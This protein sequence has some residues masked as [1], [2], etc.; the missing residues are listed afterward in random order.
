MHFPC[1]GL[2]EARRT[3]RSAPC[4][5]L[6][7]RRHPGRGHVLGRVANDSIRATLYAGCKDGCTFRT[8]HSGQVLKCLHWRERLSEN[9]AGDQ[10]RVAASIRWA[11][12]SRIM[13]L[14]SYDDDAFKSR[15]YAALLS[16]SSSSWPNAR[17]IDSFICDQVRG[18]GK[19]ETRQPGRVHVC[20]WDEKDASRGSQPA[21]LGPLF[22]LLGKPTKR[23]VVLPCTG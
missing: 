5:V 9:A 23:C 17:A 16:S 8:R 22:E 3:C 14:W 18:D 1:L 12:R 2:G 21:S 6:L 19:D 10:L 13:G 20:D 15:A 7:S 4:A 11:H